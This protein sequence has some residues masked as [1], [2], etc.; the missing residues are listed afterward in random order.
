MTLAEL[1]SQVMALPPSDKARLVQLLLPDITH[2]FS[3]IEKTPGICG[4][5]ARVSHTRIAIWLLE[6][7]RQLGMSDAAI[8]KAYPYLSAVD[9]A[10]AWVYASANHIEIEA[11]IRQNE[12]LSENL[13]PINGE[14]AA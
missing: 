6:R 7:M 9:L 2:A 1:E 4:G 8:L 12:L 3:G 14:T 11:E 5:S 10:N 13:E